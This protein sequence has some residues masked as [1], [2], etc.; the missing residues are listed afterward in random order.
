MNVGMLWLDDTKNRTL[1]EKVERAAE[2]YQ[3]KYGRSPELCLV[4][5]ALL[6]EKQTIGQIEVAPAK[7]VMPAYLW[8]GMKTSS[9][10]SARA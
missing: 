8:L 9:A 5:T 7:T 4:N 10:T 6:A 1:A 2:Y 3:N